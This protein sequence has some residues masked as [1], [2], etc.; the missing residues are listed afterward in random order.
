MGRKGGGE[1]TRRVSLELK[2][3]ATGPDRSRSASH[4]PKLENRTASLVLDPLHV[5]FFDY[6][7]C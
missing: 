5:F 6:C 3:P 7:T 1:G 2:L 4:F